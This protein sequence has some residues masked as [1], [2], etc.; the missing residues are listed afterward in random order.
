MKEV[1]IITNPET[2]KV[3]SEPTRFKILTLLRERPMS[4]N[5][6]SIA[7]GKDRTTVYRHIKALESEGLV[8]EIDSHGN[9]KIYARTARMFLI[10]V[11]P[12]ES[13]AEFRQA[14]LQVEARKLVQILER[15]G[16]KI[17]DRERLE[18][19]AREVLDEIEIKS[20]PIIRR[21]SE[22]NVELT[23]IELFHLLNMLVF[24]QS[25]EL[26]EK[27]REVKALVEF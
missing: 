14:Y 15:A 10:K 23:E 9:E 1:L 24:L 26:C 27:A 7:T 4:I 19:I 21:I 12:D 2:V 17:K 25:C 11:E 22:A 6:L 3:L 18:K 13:I 5:E 20:Q 16:F 8:E